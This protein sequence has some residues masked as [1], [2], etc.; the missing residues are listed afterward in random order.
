M[1]AVA[2]PS[3]AFALSNCGASARAR[4]PEP[5]RT[6]Q[7]RHG[8]EDLAG[9]RVARE[10]HVAALHALVDVGG[11][12]LA[13]HAA[14]WLP[15]DKGLP[16]SILVGGV[17]PAPRPEEGLASVGVL[18]PA[19]GAD[20]DP[21]EEE[22]REDDGSGPGDESEGC[23]W[24]HVRGGGLTTKSSPRCGRRHL[25]EAIEGARSRARQY[26][27]LASVEESEG[28]TKD[29]KLYEQVIQPLG[30]TLLLVTAC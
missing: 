30:C 19:A 22:R 16:A 6:Y 11:R 21:D 28:K 24:N 12:V 9:R 14:V 4:G 17:K 7:A 23:C 20:E 10:D 3:S 5:G 1:P 29:S 13:Q 8:P 25:Q 18:G 26:V 27:L 2:R 15:V